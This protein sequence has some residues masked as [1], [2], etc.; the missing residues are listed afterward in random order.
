M[1][2]IGARVALATTYHPQTNGLMERANRTLLSMIRRVCV[3]ESERWVERLPLLEFAYNS[4][5]H[6]V[7]KL[8]PFM[9][10]Y[11]FQP[12]LPASFLA[13]PGSL[14]S[15]PSVTTFCRQ[16]QQATH[17]IWEQVRK[18]SQ[19]AGERAEKREN[20]KRGN[21]RYQKGDEVLCWRHRLQGQSQLRKH[22]LRYAGP[23][24]IAEVGQGHVRLEGLPKGTPERLNVEYVRPYRRLEAAE[25]WRDKPP[26]PAR[27]EGSGGDIQWEVERILDH[28]KRGSKMYFQVQWKGY[29]QPTWEPKR[30]LVN[31]KELLREYGRIRRAEGSS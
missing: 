19:A 10:N 24:V 25:R 31:C 22:E 26:P 30:N 15:S 5:V 8:S 12:R 21:P 23:Y 13:S 16:V 4:S 9:A 18:E 29:A 7:T 6:S 14:P 17:R 20:V 28:K 2:Q 3:G 27:I 11:S 1:Q